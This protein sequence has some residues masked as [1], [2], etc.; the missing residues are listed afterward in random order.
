MPPSRQ[1]K[2]TMP[3]I[4]ET[5]IELADAEGL[6]A[7][8]MRKLATTLDA[9]TMSLYRHIS[10]KDQL[11][12][13][14]AEVAGAAFAYPYDQDGSWT[15]RER[16][17]IAVDLDWALF[18]RH[19]WMVFAYAAPRY[20]LSESSLACLRWLADGLTDL[21]VD[22]EEATSMALSVWDLT[23]GVALML[24]TDRIL[25]TGPREASAPDGLKERLDVGVESL[26]RGFAARGPD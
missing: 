15:W 19:P 10:D 23:N 22:D 5:A 25:H 18:E 17:T 24:A 3:A 11:I 8:S 2:L 26:C 13:A 12:G 14:M 16:V 4:V 1:P 6:G 7:L 21:G 9:G 20:T